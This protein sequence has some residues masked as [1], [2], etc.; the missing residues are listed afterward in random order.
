MNFKSL[1][2]SSK[3]VIVLMLF[4]VGFFTIQNIN[5]RFW[6]HDFE[7]YY[8]ASN[9]LVDGNQ[10]YGEAFGL[11]SG[12]YKYS[13]LVLFLFMPLSALPFTIAKVIYFFVLCASILVAIR[14]ISGFIKDVFFP[15]SVEGVMLRVQLFMFLACLLQFYY[16]LHLGNVNSILLLLVVI[17]LI[18]HQRGK[19]ITASLLLAIAVLVKPHFLLLFP[20]Y[21]I[22][23]EIKF[24]GITVVGIIIGLFIP[25]LYTGWIRNLQL[26]KDWVTTMMIHN[27][28]PVTGYDTVYSWL[29]KIIG[30]F[31]SFQP[32]LW[33]TIVII[34]I[35]YVL[36]LLFIYKNRVEERSVQGNRSRQQSFVFEFFLILGAI[37]NLTVTDFEH[38]MFSLPLISFLLLYI[39][40]QKPSLRFIV[41]SVFTLVLY[42]G[43]IRDLV[44]KT[45]S[46]W[47]T[48]N[49]ILGLG[50]MMIIAL[51]L[52]V[53][54][55][56]RQKQITG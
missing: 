47:M 5:N 20:L 49:G 35:V 23:R 22:R 41:I 2:P 27:Q 15:K 50:N 43:N 55:R 29:Y 12:Y 17:G 51:V 31:Y 14:Y 53:W 1:S 7:V 38:F 11:D 52:I 32:G 36:L 25:A 56:I 48:A 9:A 3:L 46:A 40:N 6:M 19:T 45:I 34:T 8:S 37:P 18:A 30:S 39:Y 10:V 21:L 54:P 33:F 26:L 24:I 16:E 44:G 4:F 13:P 28:S 42:G